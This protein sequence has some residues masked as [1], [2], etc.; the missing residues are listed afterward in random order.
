MSEKVFSIADGIA[1]Q[2]EQL[3]MYKC[4][5]NEESYNWL[6][7]FLKWDNNRLIEGSDNGYSVMRGTDIQ[8]ALFN[9][10]SRK[11]HGYGG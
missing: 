10:G 7:D 11:L 1:I 2:Q 6:E 4:V 3:R 5:L 8:N 9:Y